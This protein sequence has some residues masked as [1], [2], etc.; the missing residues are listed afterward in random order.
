VRRKKTWRRLALS[1]ATAG[2][3][4]LGASYLAA[5]R[6]ARRLISAQ[7]LVPSTARREEMLAELHRAVSIV[8][9]H[10]HAGS[11]RA[12]AA[13]AAIFA[14]PG[15]PEGR[16]T[17]LFL[18][19]KG[20]CSAEWRPD[21]LRAVQLGYNVLV[22]DLRGHRPSE[23]DFVT[24]GFLEREDL[25]RLLETARD[26]FGIDPGRLGI[27]ACS[28]GCTVALEFAAN[29]PGIGALWLESPYA[30]PLEM[31]RHYLSVA[32]G[33]PWWLLAMTTRLAVS[34][35]AAKVRRELHVTDPTAGLGRI[36][37]VAALSRVEGRLCLVHGERDGLVPPRFAARLESALPANAI[38]WKVA[39]AGHCHHDDE[40]EKVVAEEYQRRWSDFFVANLP[41]QL[42]GSP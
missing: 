27:H 39:G 28:A 34:R 18:H 41:P 15:Q 10:R 31:A 11:P 8:V 3:A 26:R 14:S 36:D 38:V 22:P 25:A 35:A 32:T 2:L 19:G 30:D 1:L 42:E 23:G 37:P 7:G 20:G 40:A 13:L 29:R 33:A 5:R 17:I 9:D 16:A 24:Y 6:L 12:P 4:Y 21:A